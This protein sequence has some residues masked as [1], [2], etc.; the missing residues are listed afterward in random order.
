MNLKKFSALASFGVLTAGVLVSVKPA[1]SLTLNAGST[2]NIAGD[3]TFR[4]LGV[5]D[6]RNSEPLS[7]IDFLNFNDPQPDF[8]GTGQFVITGGTDSFADFAPD[9]S[10]PANPVFQIGTIKDLPIID[11]P[12]PFGDPRYLE[13]GAVGGFVPVEDFLA[14]STPDNIV[15]FDLEELNAPVYTQSGT[16]AS[17]S[18]SVTISA[19]GNFDTDMQTDVPGQFVFAAEFV[20]RTENE[21][22]NILRTEGGSLVG[23]SN[24]GNGIVGEDV[25]EPSSIIGLVAFGL[26]SASFLGGRKKQKQLG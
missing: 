19:A 1:Q 14:F 11:P 16:G 10:D 26:A 5:D 25:P 17:A 24:S 7:T 13:P 23:E 3:A 9:L 4:A 12:Y 8:P 6:V 2:I 15:N 21:V 20:G 18:T 22:R